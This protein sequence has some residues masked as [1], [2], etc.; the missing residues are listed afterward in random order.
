MADKPRSNTILF[1]IFITILLLMAI[2]LIFALWPVGRS[3]GLNYG[4][5]AGG[6]LYVYIALLSASI[7]LFF[8][9]D[10]IELHFQHVDEE[11]AI[12]KYIP[13][14][15][16]P[17]ILA[18]YYI[19]SVKTHFLGDGYLQLANLPNFN[20]P[21]KSVEA[22]EV[23]I[24]RMLLRIIGC[25]SEDC[26]RLTYQILSIFSGA[27]FLV[28]LL[29]ISRKLKLTH[30]DRFLFMLF[31][32]LAGFTLLFYGYVEHYSLTAS[33]LFLFILSAAS[34]LINKRKSI[35][36]LLAFGVACYLH[37]ISLIY[38]PAAVIYVVL[39][40]PGLQPGKFWRKYRTYIYALT[41][42]LFI[43]LYVLIRR[44]S[45]LSLQLIALP[46]NK[47]RFTIDNYTLFSASHLIDYANL[48]IFLVPNFVFLLAIIL[49]RSDK[50]KINSQ[51]SVFLFTASA[52]GLLV[53]FI[54]NPVLGMA[55][56][57]DLMAVMLIGA[58]IASIYLLVVNLEKA[59]YKSIL[60]SM[61]FIYNLATFVPW[62]ALHNSIGGMLDYAE[63]IAKLD[64]QHGRTTMFNL[65]TFCNKMGLSDRAEALQPY[66]N[67][68]YASVSYNLKVTEL[69]AERKIAEAEFYARHAIAAS[70]TAAD[71]Y[72]NLALCLLNKRQPGQ[73]LQSLK[74]AGALSPDN[75][76]IEYLI[77]SGYGALRN[78]KEGLKHLRRSI[79]YDKSNGA[80][81]MGLGLYYFNSGRLD[82]A[83]YYYT[84]LPESTYSDD[85][86]YCLGRTYLAMH[87]PEAATANF[88]KYLAKGQNP[89]LIDSTKVIL[90]RIKP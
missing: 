75:S 2:R 83:L 82:S 62:L 56:D 8:F 63:Y 70:P 57:W 58:A 42:L 35:L 60:L 29:F 10:K 78:Y 90:S 88:E 15:L 74:I 7:L 45:I 67:T 68:T 54:F 12:F 53:A 4:A 24:H 81:Y 47:W 40:L 59:K 77:G 31:S 44:S 72:T 9:K 76:E 41:I 66:W 25:H 73:A 38:L 69:L 43:V 32:L 20:I 37:R 50:S 80:P 5:F 21:G 11:S 55:R 23:A 52:A 16:A 18:C 1:G 22:G 34:G 84:A 87:K 33:M 71:G 30:F 19:F 39:I 27:V 86:Y 46:I 6:S 14:L 64:P 65:L 79:E 36:P 3:W 48:L 61:I 26:V 28:S 49:A 89:A 17:I 51:L 85:I 13:L